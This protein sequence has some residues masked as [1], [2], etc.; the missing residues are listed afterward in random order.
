MTKHLAI[1][2]GN[3]HGLVG[4]KDGAL[5]GAAEGFAD[6]L[7]ACDPT[8]AFTIIRPH[9]DDHELHSAIFDGCDGIVFTGS[10]NRWSA[11]EAEAAPARDVMAAALETG[12]PV[13]GSCYGL[14]L[15]V[16]VLGGTNQAN[17]TRTEFAIARDITLT[18]AGAAHPLYQGKPHIFDARCMHR[19]EIARLPSDAVSLS[20][21]AH[22]AHQAMVYERGGVQFWGVQY[23]PELGFQDLANYIRRNDVDSFEDACYFAS[24]L[25][26]LDD[27]SHIC[28]D[29]E[30]LDEAHETALH[31]AYQLGPTLTDIA[32]HR[33]ELINF[34]KLL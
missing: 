6:T 4:Q 11:D 3:H 30:R 1:I 26:V 17:P 31:Q 27:I 32:V 28:A 18:E 13:F 25:G 15:A 7:R 24:Q 8:L 10:A 9:F 23:H 19:D 14:Q 29:F 34:L 2:E 33:R 12:R 5:Y 22:S 20:F 21:N 16:A